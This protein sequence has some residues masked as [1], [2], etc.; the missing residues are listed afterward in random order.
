MNQIAIRPEHLRQDERRELGLPSTRCNRCGMFPEQI[1]KCLRCGRNGCGYCLY[2]TG[3]GQYHHNCCPL[4]RSSASWN[5]AQRR[6]FPIQL[7]DA[8]VITREQVSFSIRHQKCRGCG[9]TF[10][11]GDWR[12]R[13]CNKC[14]AIR[15]AYR[16][17]EPKVVKTKTCRQ[18]GHDFSTTNGQRWYC[19]DCPPIQTG[20]R[21]RRSPSVVIRQEGT[22]KASPHYT[23]KAKA[24]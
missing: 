21:Q 12:Y 15:S 18:C 24:S 16:R 20:F 2:E 6:V 8:P 17:E 11:L 23:K 14:R 19:D 1:T 10:Y 5:H 13:Y 4:K 22:Y 3:E 9:V 7:K